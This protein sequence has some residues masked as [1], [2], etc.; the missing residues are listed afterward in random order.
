M[1]VEFLGINTRSQVIL[2]PTG[3]PG[4]WERFIKWL[5]KVIWQIILVTT[6]ILYTVIVFKIGQGF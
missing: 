2:K 3:R 6:L 1:S 4:L 5:G